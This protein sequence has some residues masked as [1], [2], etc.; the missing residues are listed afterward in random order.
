[1]LGEHQRFLRAAFA[2]H[3]GREVHTEGDAF[4]VAFARASDAIAAAVA[5][6]RAPASQDWPEG[7]DVRVRM[8]VHTGEAEGPDG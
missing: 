2:E 8:G 4:F 3:G 7:A 1:M 5:A 6:Q